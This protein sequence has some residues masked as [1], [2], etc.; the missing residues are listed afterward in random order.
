MR[1]GLGLG[2]GSGQG[3]GEVEIPA[4]FTIAAGA[5]FSFKVRL[6]ELGTVISTG[7]VK[8]GTSAN[9]TGTEITINATADYATNPGTIQT[10]IYVLGGTAGGTIIFPKK[11]KIHYLYI[12]TPGAGA[13]TG[14]ITGMA[15]TYLYINNPGAGAITG[16]ITGMALTYLYIY[17][18][19]AGAIT[20]SITGMALTYLHIYNPGAGAITGSITGM[21]LTYLRVYNP[22]AGDIVYSPKASY[23]SRLSSNVVNS[24]L[25]FT[26]VD[27]YNKQI[28][29]SITYVNSGVSKPLVI[30]SS[31]KDITVQLATDGSGVSTTTANDII[32]AWNQTAIATIAK[33]GDGTGIVQ[34][35][36]K[37]YFTTSLG[38]IGIIILPANMGTSKAGYRSLIIA[39]SEKTASLSTFSIAATDADECPD[40]AGA[41]D[42]D[43]N[44]QVSTAVTALIADVGATAF[45]AAWKTIWGI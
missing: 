35:M 30:S 37:K 7:D 5:S 31:G 3:G 17:A 16:S 26:D 12:N 41:N 44:Q 4:I 6:S 18:P 38:T 14:S 9:P 29:P 43:G 2:F 33:Y 25:V 13:I 20:G 11:S 32:A 19:G 22:G 24:G 34:A 1:M 45:S 21:A 28:L 10:T 27:D 40:Y 36:A 8:I 23:N 15:L 39:A 42:G